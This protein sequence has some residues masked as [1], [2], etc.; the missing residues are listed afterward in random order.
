MGVYLYFSER[1]SVLLWAYVF[2]VFVI[3]CVNVCVVC[4]VGLR[5]DPSY[6]NIATLIEI[7]FVFLRSV[8]VSNQPIV[9]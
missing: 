6:F 7:M 5:L 1:V 2:S 9:D 4:F 8:C 3:V